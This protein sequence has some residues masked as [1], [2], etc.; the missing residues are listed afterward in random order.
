MSKMCAICHRGPVAGRQFKRRGMARSK[1]GAGIKVTRKSA[2]YFHV[3]L[4]RVKILLNNTIQRAYVCTR[5]IKSGRIV[6]AL[7]RS[8]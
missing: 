7:K 6:K 2:R 3:N 8:L 4:Q 5:C 1:G